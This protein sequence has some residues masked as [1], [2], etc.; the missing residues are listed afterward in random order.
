MTFGTGHHETT[1][2]MIKMME[3]MNIENRKVFDFGTGTG[4][5]AILA[6][7]TG[8]SEILAIDNDPLAVANAIKNAAFN[9]CNN[10]SVEQ[11]ESA[12]MKKFYFDI[13]LANINKNVL[14]EEAKNL[15]LTL[16]KGGFL[17][18]SGILKED[19]EDVKNTFEN[20][21]LK[22]MKTLEKGK[23]IAMKFVAY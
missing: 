3:E 17:T 23:W 1:Y 9:Q 15:S 8:A 6:E 2:L 13:V 20:N 18:L 11:G 14:L 4:I 21:S 19:Y 22:L 12:D 10:I 16:R 5:L 7:K